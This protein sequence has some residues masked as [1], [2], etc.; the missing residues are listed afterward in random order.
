MRQAD[1]YITF[2]VLAAEQAINDA[3]FMSSY[4]TNGVAVVV[5][6]AIGGLPFIEDNILKMA[7]KGPR[8]LSPFP[9]R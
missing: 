7:T 3:N 4:S 5:G 6:S 9:V 1:D 8:K 2:S